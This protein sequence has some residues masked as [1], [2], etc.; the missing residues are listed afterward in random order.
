MSNSHNRRRFIQLAGT[1]AAAS[2]AGCSDLNSFGSS[3]DE[4]NGEDYGSS[5]RIGATVT[6]S[7]DE[8]EKFQ[9]EAEEMD[10]SE[11][12][13]EQTKLIE[14]A[15]EDFEGYAEENDI[16]IEESEKEYGLFI[17][18][19]SAEALIEAMLEGPI[20]QLMTGDRYD[21]TIQQYEQQQQMQE[22]QSSGEETEESSEDDADENESE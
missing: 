21:Q 17:V 13:E 22:A 3:Q 8:M 16:S 11:L 9:E 15:A 6:P 4:G 2:I 1:G 7:E 19:G 5:E 12:M 14:D 20:G 18:E 10:Q